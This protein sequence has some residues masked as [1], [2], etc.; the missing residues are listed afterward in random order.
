MSKR[1]YAQLIVQYYSD[2]VNHSGAGSRADNVLLG[3]V[4]VVDQV[5]AEV[6]MSLNEGRGSE[7]QPLAQADVLSD[8]FGEET[9]QYRSNPSW[10]DTYC[11]SRPRGSEGWCFQCSRRSGLKENQ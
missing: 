7:R 6:E 10:I 2:Q 11:C 8:V 4:Q 3:L 1:S 9:G 5:I